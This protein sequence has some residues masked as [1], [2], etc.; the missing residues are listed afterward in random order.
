MGRTAPF[1]EP[2][3]P[4]LSGACRTLAI[5]GAVLLTGA[6]ALAQVVGP[7]SARVADLTAGLFCAPP[8]G[9]RRPAPDTMT[10]WIHV[11]DEPVRMVAEGNEAPAVLGMGFGVRYAIAPGTDL[12]TRYTVTHPPIPPSGITEQHWDGMALAGGGDTAFFQF[13]VPEELQP[14]TWTFSVEAGG[15][16]LFTMAFTVRAAQDLPAL[17]SL[18]RGGALLSANPSGRG[19]AG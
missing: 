8:E 7:V 17:A 2:R 16:T 1:H 12:V 5:A 18:C 13:D 9:G 10:G 19:A 15:E 14:G 6:P 11:P 3:T 4:G